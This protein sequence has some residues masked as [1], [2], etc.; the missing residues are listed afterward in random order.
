MR[1]QEL[2]SNSNIFS[3]SISKAFLSLVF[4]LSIHGSIQAQTL[5]QVSESLIQDIKKSQQRL[6]K[7]EET[8]AK[9]KIVL[10]KAIAIEQKKLIFLKFIW[11]KNYLFALFF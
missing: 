7:R 11:S 1:F 8:I 6:N 9:E 5:N 10:A 4:L 2:L 3:T